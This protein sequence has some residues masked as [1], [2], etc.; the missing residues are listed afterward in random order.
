MKQRFGTRREGPVDFVRAIRFPFDD[1]DWPIKIVVGTLLSFIPFFAQG[2]QV[3]VAR[4]VIRGERRPLP[5]TD[6]LGQIF[7]DGVM[8]TLALF[9]YFLPAA[10]L[11][12]LLLTPAMFTGED[13]LGGL[14]VCLSSICVVGFMVLYAIPATGMYTMGVIRYVETGNFSEFMRFGALWT[15]VRDNLSLLIMLLL[16]FVA[17]G[18]V[19]S[20]M[21][22]TVILLPFLGFL[23]EVSSGHLIGQAGLEIS[24]GY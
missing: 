22:F 18:V 21:G 1:E 15:E 4:N 10:L 9:I 5:G 8:A 12:C 17:L 11:T 23:Y 3:R 19:V 14:L 24:R 7:T 20:V 13:E 16:Y 2:Y 6:R